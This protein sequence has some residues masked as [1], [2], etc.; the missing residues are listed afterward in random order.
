MRIL[1]ITNNYK[2]YSG[3]VVSSIDAT[4][5]ELR[6][7]GHDVLLVTLDFLGKIQKKE[8]GIVRIACPFRFIYKTNIMAIPWRPSHEL[9]LLAKEYHP[10]IIHVH[11]PFLLGESGLSVAKRLNIPCVFTYHTFYEHYAH[12]VPIPIFCSKPIIS[13]KINKFC[14]AVDG[15]IVPST[16]VKAHIRNQGIISLI[17][18]IPSSLRTSFLPCY[19]KQKTSDNKFFFELLLVSRFVQ[20]KNIPFVL[21][22]L[23]RLPD[24]VR[25]TLVGYGAEYDN[26]QRLAFDVFCFSSKRVR[27]IHKPE[28]TVLIDLYRSADLFIF[29]SQSDTQGL[30]IIEAMSQGLPVVALD[31]PGQKDVVRNGEN[32][33]IITNDESA[34]LVIQNIIINADL[35]KNLK[36]G[37][38]ATAEKYS[39][40]IHIN[41]LLNL[42]DTLRTT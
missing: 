11:H 42:Y 8:I 7:M 6:A 14:S 24:Y 4:M 20:E 13:W 17:E 34:A 28:Q 15:I 18:V 36:N 21:E 29:P 3:G 39:P 35:H 5:Q 38:R 22:V 41:Q 37:A 23:K 16:S 19:D 32:G 26:I 31:G 30:V 1:F 10:D 33:F 2:P 12:Y 27:F 40:A 25:L 9:F